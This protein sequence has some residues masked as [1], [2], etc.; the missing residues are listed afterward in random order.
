MSRTAGDRKSNRTTHRRSPRQRAA[1]ALAL[2]LVDPTRKHALIAAQLG[3][4]IG[5]EDFT[6]VVDLDGGAWALRGS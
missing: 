4:P 6:W 2:P 3:S 5:A 1:A